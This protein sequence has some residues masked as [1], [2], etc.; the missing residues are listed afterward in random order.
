[1]SRPA[2][3]SSKAVRQALM[4]MQPISLIRANLRVSCKTIGNQVTA[5]GLQRVYLTRKERLLIGG[6]RRMKRSQVP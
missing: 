4:L 1:M 6:R 3:A 2:N 5:L